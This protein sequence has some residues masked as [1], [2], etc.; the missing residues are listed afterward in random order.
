[1]KIGTVGAIG[2]GGKK[3]GPGHPCFIIAEAGVNHNGDIGTAELLVEAASAAGADAVKFQTFRAASL[4]SRNAPKAQY[5]TESGDREESHLEMLHRLEL[6]H[7]DH[8]HLS[9]YAAQQGILFLSTPFDEASA[10]LLSGLDVPLF[11]IGSGELTNPGLLRHVAGKNKPVVLSTG[12]AYLAEV[13]Q[14]VRVLRSGGCSELVLLHCTSNYP[15]ALAD[16]NLRAMHVLR[17]ACN[18]PVGYSDHTQGFEA[19]LGAVALGAVVLEKHLTLDKHMAGPDHAASTEPEE[20][21]TLVESVRRLEQALGAESKHPVPAE[22]PVRAVTR[23]SI[24]VALDLPAGAALESR[25]L[26]IKRPGTGIPA[27]DIERVLGRRLTRPIAA[28]E[29]LQWA[30]LQ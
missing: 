13:Q 11:K 12:M 10:D 3:I 21:K 22:F 23:R 19:A 4:V 15:T 2:V 20:F 7:D 17:D 1:M 18:V 5:Q 27:E 16:C 9:T 29:I 28:D 26:S 14:A 24:V 30:D 8:R 6:S 25:H